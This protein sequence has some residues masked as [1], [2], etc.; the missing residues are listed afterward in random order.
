MSYSPARKSLQ[1]EIFW[2]R[3][4]ALKEVIN[5]EWK[6]LGQLSNLVTINAGLSM[7]LGWS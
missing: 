7:V 6:C 3:D 4:E 5:K 2:E 1:Y